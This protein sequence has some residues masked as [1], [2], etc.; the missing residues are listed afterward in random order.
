MS[1]T[2]RGN[3]R[4]I[5]L[6]PPSFSVCRLEYRLTSATLSIQPIFYLTLGRITEAWKGSP[7]TAPEIYNDQRTFIV[8]NGLLLSLVFTRIISPFRYLDLIYIRLRLHIRTCRSPN[9]RTFLDYLHLICSPESDM[10]KKFQSCSYQM[11][12]KGG[13]CENFGVKNIRKVDVAVLNGVI[14]SK[15]YSHRKSGLKSPFQ[16]QSVG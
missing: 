11:C 4:I 14:F 3:S 16:W 9:L 10:Q 7:Q 8:T 2:L 13:N 15:K 5:R 6:V 12:E 1:R